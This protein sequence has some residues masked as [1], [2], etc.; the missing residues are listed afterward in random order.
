MSRYHEKRV[1]PH[2]EWG[3]ESELTVR[4][5]RK[6]KGQRQRRR[7]KQKREAD[8]RAEQR[9]CEKERGKRKVPHPKAVQKV[10]KAHRVAKEKEETPE[11]ESPG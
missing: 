1:Y 4:I 3:E 7:E 8:K 2:C 10:A 11:Q 5:K 6:R 9:D